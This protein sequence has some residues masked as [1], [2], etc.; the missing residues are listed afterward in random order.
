MTAALA[1]G[2]GTLSGTTTVNAVNGVA[3]FTDLMIAGSGAH[4]IAF[5]AASLASATSDDAAKE[6]GAVEGEA[7]GGGKHPRFVLPFAVRRIERVVLDFR[8]EVG[9]VAV[10]EFQWWAAACYFSGVIVCV[11]RSGS[12]FGKKASMV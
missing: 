6:L 8:S 5:T 3:T 4:T 9:A 1:S 12:K 10:G 11:L 2:S 7:K